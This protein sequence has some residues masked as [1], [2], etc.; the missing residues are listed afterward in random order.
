[1][2][3]E[4]RRRRIVEWVESD[5]SVSVDALSRRLSVSTMTIWRDLKA[6]ESQGLVRRVRGGA[7]KGRSNVAMEPQFDIKQQVYSQEKARIAAY[8][9][10]HFVRD[11]DIII[12][13]GGTTVASMVPYLTQSNLTILTNGLNTIV[14]AAARVPH[15]TVMCCGGI[16]RDVSLT[17][18]GPQAEAFFASFRAHKFFLS[19]TGLTLADGLTDPNPLEIQVKRAMNASAEQTILLLDSS[20]FGV[21]SLSPIIPLQEVDILVTDAG[22]SVDVLNA[23]REMGIEVHIAP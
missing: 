8:A 15:L 13:E 20:K 17:F 5:G 23:L 6:L 7:V 11:N 22:A 14:R 19:A 9:A 10:A 18:V 16:L 2:L 4:E 12:L 21:R 3:I 1:M